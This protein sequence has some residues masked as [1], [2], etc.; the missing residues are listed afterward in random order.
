MPDNRNKLVKLEQGSK[1]IWI[2]TV[3]VEFLEEK[4]VNK[5]EI[6]TA[7]GAKITVDASADD[8]AEALADKTIDTT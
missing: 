1:A 2:D 8:V 5:T 7:S 6:I 3:D 4:G